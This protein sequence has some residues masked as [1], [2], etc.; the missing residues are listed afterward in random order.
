MTEQERLDEE[1]RQ[2]KIERVR[3][4]MNVEEKK[5]EKYSKGF[6]I[7]LL[8][9]S[10][11]FLCFLVSKQENLTYK[12]VNYKKIQQIVQYDVGVD[13]VEEK[14]ISVFNRLN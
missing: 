11:L 12:D 5:T 8:I 13:F 4:E 6:Q 2:R 3:K 14:I 9:A 1:S 7:R 10:A